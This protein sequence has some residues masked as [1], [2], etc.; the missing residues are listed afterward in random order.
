MASV[1]P[2]R[3]LDWR[4]DAGGAIWT[5]DTWLQLHESLGGEQGLARLTWN[6]LPS[7]HGYERFRRYVPPLL[8]W[9]LQW[10]LPFADIIRSRWCP[11]CGR[12]A[13]VLMLSPTG[14]TAW[15]ASCIEREVQH[16]GDIEDEKPF[17]DADF[18]FTLLRNGNL[19][20]M[21]SVLYQ[22]QRFLVYLQA[23]LRE[24]DM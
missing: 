15:C 22:D 13:H 8:P 23:L 20:V 11:G 16:M 24:L 2:S 7:Q 12:N 17:V 6:M 9:P 1:I 4:C 21:R 14:A 10:L 19:Y 18:V 5:W 3:N